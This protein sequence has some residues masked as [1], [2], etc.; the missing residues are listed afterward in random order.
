MSRG[1][2]KCC[3]WWFE[4][5]RGLSITSLAK[6]VILLCHPSQPA[7][8][9]PVGHSSAYALTTLPCTA[10]KAQSR[11][12]RSCLQPT[13][14]KRRLCCDCFLQ[15]FS[16]SSAAA[17]MTRSD[18]SDNLSF[19]LDWRPALRWVGVPTC[20]AP[21][22]G[23]LKHLHWYFPY[24]WRPF[25]RLLLDTLATGMCLGC[26]TPVQAAR[27]WG[28]SSQAIA[29]GSTCTPHVSAARRYQ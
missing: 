3:G 24:P 13:S 11:G 19:D 8:T 17:A 20:C 22:P 29:A 6:K 21:Q 12:M 10:Q 18:S 15:A 9:R 14:C 16:S 5:C 28:S 26:Q 1:S 4:A 25:S 7:T 27:A 23:L 2:A